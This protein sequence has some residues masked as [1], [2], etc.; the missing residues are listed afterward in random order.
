[1]KV[2]SYEEKKAAVGEG[3]SAEIYNKQKKL[4]NT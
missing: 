3:K 2:N 4:I 1:M